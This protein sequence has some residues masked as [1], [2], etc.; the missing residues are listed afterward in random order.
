MQRRL[1]I[2]S[3]IADEISELLALHEEQLL[4]VGGLES[5]HKMLFM[6]DIIEIEHMKSL[7]I[8]IEN[9]CAKSVHDDDGEECDHTAILKNGGR[10][11]Q[12]KGQEVGDHY[13]P[14]TMCLD[15]DRRD[16]SNDNTLKK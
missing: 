12:D 13:T 6:V 16:N 14:S 4:L 2:V 8:V 11:S 10:E 7:L 15:K 3:H 5:D 9:D 1:Q